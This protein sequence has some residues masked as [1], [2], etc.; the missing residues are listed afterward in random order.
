MPLYCSYAIP[1]Y[2]ALYC[3]LVLCLYVLFIYHAHTRPICCTHML[4]NAQMPR[5]FQCMYR[6]RLIIYPVLSLGHLHITAFPFLVHFR[7][8]GTRIARR[9]LSDV[10]RRRSHFLRFNLHRIRKFL[11][12]RCHGRHPGPTTNS[13]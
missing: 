1:I 4:C 6:H 5:L 10:F 11:L 3:T 2:H 13:S 9:F 7:I 12:N 8:L